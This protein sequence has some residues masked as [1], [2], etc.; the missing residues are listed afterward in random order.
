MSWT[1][2]NC[3]YHYS[4]SLRPLLSKV[5][6]SWTQALW[7]HNSMITMIVT[8]WLTGG[9]NWNK[10][11]FISQVG[12]NKMLWEFFMLLRMTHDFK[13]RNY[14]WNFS[15]YYFQT[16]V[17]CRLNKTVENENRDKGRPLYMFIIRLVGLGCLC[18]HFFVVTFEVRKCESSNSPFQD[19]CFC[20]FW[21]L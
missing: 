10:G 14:L 5:R 3:Q 6:V 2:P 17:D 19:F 15:I 20:Y 18:Y 7:Y 13:L 21:S 1:Y 9:I 16:V 12:W 8:K 4:C 11:W